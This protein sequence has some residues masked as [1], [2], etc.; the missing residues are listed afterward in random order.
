MKKVTLKEEKYYL[1]YY[2]TT[3]YRVVCVT[4]HRLLLFVNNVELLNQL[5][6]YLNLLFY[7]LN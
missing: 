7:D 6:F 5:E 3:W 1:E 4:V 2:Q